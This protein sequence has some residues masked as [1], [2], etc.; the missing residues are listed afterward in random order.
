MTT[1]DSPATTHDDAPRFLPE[2]AERLPLIRDLRPMQ[3]DHPAMR[4]WDAPHGDPETW[5]LQIADRELPGP[6]GP[7]PVRIYAPSD[8][9]R[10]G[11]ADD[12]RAGAVSDPGAPRPC[13]VWLHGGAFIGGDLDMPE[14]HEVAR[15]IAGRAGAVVVS[16]FYRLCDVPADMG[17]APATTNPRGETGVHAPIP[18]DDAHAAFTW[19]R[20]HAADLGIDPSR[21][22]VGGAS[23]GGALAASLSQRLADEG[24]PARRA[25]L[26]YPVVHAV[27]PE[28]TPEEA[29]ALAVTPEVLRFHTETTVAMNENY[30]G[31]PV[32]TATPYEFAALADEDALRALPATYIEVDEFDD[33]RRSGRAYAEQLRDAGV[34]VTFEIRRGVP[35]GHLNRVGLSAAAQSLDRMAALLGE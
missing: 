14:A 35:H 3:F 22:A 7:V 2:L 4:A 17:G 15:G 20:E 29:A 24:A 18:L 27:L 16:V 28:P 32:E 9:V 10:D 19:V 12:P 21:I 11:A 1:T 5:D 26:M 23:A 30:L 8:E 34:D 6:H 31:G 13:L 25:L 33:L